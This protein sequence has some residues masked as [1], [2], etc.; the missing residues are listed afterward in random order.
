MK[1]V[2]LESNETNATYTLKYCLTA[3]EI[4]KRLLRQEP[5]YLR[6]NNALYTRSLKLAEITIQLP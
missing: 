3:H 5:K 2:S 1:Q 6:L 4:I